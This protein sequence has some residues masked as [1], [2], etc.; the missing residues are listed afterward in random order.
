MCLSLS[1]SLAYHPGPSRA[2]VARARRETRMKRWMRV[3]LAVTVLAGCNEHNRDAIE[4]NNQGTRAFRERRLQD[5]RDDFALAAQLDPKFD[6]PLYNL[7][8]V[9]FEQEHWAEAATALQ[10]AIARDP[11]N[12]E[13]QFKLGFAHYRE[14]QWVQARAAFQAATQITPSYWIAWYWL[15]KVAERLDEP[16]AA[17]QAYTTAITKA[18]RAYEVYVALGAEYRAVNERDR[19]VAVL[20]EGL[21]VAPDGVAE[22]ANMLNIRG[23]TYLDMGR[24][25]EA[26]NDLRQATRE[27]P[28]LAAPFF[29][30]GFTLSEMPQQRSEAVLYLQR[31]LSLRDRDTPREYVDVAQSRLA[32]LQSAGTH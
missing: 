18:P 24:R 32:E 5:A 16:Q 13:Y 7:A 22:R 27:A 2:A 20:T 26:I 28:N 25:D 31:F 4:K 9:H 19:A 1:L 23:N 30:L 6:Q 14:S 15:G 8:L 11:H 12:P 3:I 17:L 10:G 29:S 21:R